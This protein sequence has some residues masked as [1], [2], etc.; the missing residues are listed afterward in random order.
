M[1]AAPDR[2]GF[3]D[4]AAEAQLCFRA[5]LDVMARPGAVREA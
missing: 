5:V 4:P 3:A 1:I 2:P